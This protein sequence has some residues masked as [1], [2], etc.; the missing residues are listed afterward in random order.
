MFENQLLQVLILLLWLELRLPVISFKRCIARRRGRN[1]RRRNILSYVTSSGYT[2]QGQLPSEGK[3]QQ[4]T[5]KDGR[6]HTP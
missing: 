2:L 1:Q 4:S 6:I 3:R 5:G